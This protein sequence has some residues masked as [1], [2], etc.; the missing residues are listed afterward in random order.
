M[1]SYNIFFFNSQ[2]NIFIFSNKTAACRVSNLEFKPTSIIVYLSFDLPC[3]L[4]L[5]ILSFKNFYL[6]KQHHHHH[7]N[8]RVCWKKEVQ[9]I[10]F[11]EPTL[12]SLRAPPKLCA[13]SAII[14]T[15]YSFE[16][17]FSLM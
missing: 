1:S 7:S 9:V 14:D 15:L 4:R 13:A 5:T 16:S 17:F 3:A 2:S 6:Q 10:S 8:P 11:K 12:I